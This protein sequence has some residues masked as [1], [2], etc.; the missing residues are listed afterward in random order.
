[1]ELSIS[2]HRRLAGRTKLP[3]H[4]IKRMWSSSLYLGCFGIVGHGN[5]ASYGD[6]SPPEFLVH[7]NRRFICV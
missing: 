5:C 4:R 7:L 6:I 3:S 2:H 1:M